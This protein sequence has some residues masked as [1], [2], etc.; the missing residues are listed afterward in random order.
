MFDVDESSDPMTATKI[1]ML[2]VG[3]RRLLIDAMLRR[4]QSLPGW[5]A[6][7]ADPAGAREALTRFAAD[8]VLLEA[9]V[10]RFSGIIVGEALAELR[11]SAQ[12]VLLVGDNDADWSALAAESGAAAVLTC[13]MQMR[14][15]VEQLEQVLEPAGLTPK[16]RNP[17]PQTAAPRGEALLLA[18][19]TR[20]QEDVLRLLAIG[21]SA[22]DI[23]ASLSISPNTVRTHLQ[24]IMVKLNVSRRLE[25]V[26]FA[27]RTGL[28]ERPVGVRSS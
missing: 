8:I 22:E 27:R 23:A 19:L 4:I 17:P 3:R 5:A 15:L 13:Q 28:L 10:N 16:R 14:E 24:N 26:A 21:R 12:L 1:R 11:P 6:I 18:Q 25:A 9:E 7:S 20:R 2:M